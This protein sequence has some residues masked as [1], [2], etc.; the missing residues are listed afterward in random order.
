[1]VLFILFVSIEYFGYL[2]STIRQL[3][4]FTFLLFNGYVFVRYVL[5]PFFGMIRIGKRISP[6]QAARLLSKYYPDDLNDQVTNVLQL[7]KYLDRNPGNAGLIMAAIDQKAKSAIVF[8]FH[9]AISLKGN[10]RFL[11]Y[12]LL[13]LLVVLG[14]YLV[15]PAFLYEPAKR[16]VRYDM[17]FERPTPFQVEVVSSTEGFRHQDLEVVVQTHGEVVPSE[18]FLRMEGVRHPMSNPSSSTYS[19]TLRNLQEDK[20]FYVEAEGFTFGPFSIDVFEKPAFT[21]FHIEVDY[22][23]YS[24]LEKE[25]FS[26]MGDL[27]VLY[28]SQ[29]QWT[30]FTS[31]TDQVEFFIE[32]ETLDVEKVRKGEFSAS[33][34]ATESFDY[35]V[36]SGSEDRGRGDSLSYRV[37]VEKDAYPRIAVEEH[38]DEV[39]IAHLFYRGTIRDDF[40]FT[41]LR[42]FYRVMDQSQVSQE[43]EVPFKDEA[44]E[45]DPYMR[46]QTFYYHFDMQSVDVNPGET[47]EIY[48]EV[49]DN[50]PYHGPKSARSRV[51]SHYIPTE[52]EMVAEQRESEKR[53]QDGL[54]EGRGEAGDARD[55]VEELRRQLLESEGVGWE[56]RE[57][58]QELLDKQKQMEEHIKEMAEEKKEQEARSE[59][60]LEADE[61]LKER[62]EELQQLFDEV[63]SDEMKALFE[64]LQQ[65]MDDLDRD[66]IY[67]MLDQV[68]FEFRD[69]EHS[70]D[71]ALEMFRQFAME[72]LLQESIDRIENLHEKQD[73]LQEQT[74]QGED[75]DNLGNQQE[76]LNQ[77]YENIRDILDD[78]RETNESLS[79]PHTLDETQPT[80]EEISKSLQKAVEN[81]LENDLS[82]EAG[83]NQQDAM[84]QMDQ[85]SETLRGM[86]ERLFHEQL[87]EDARA[88]RML[89]E[90]L[91]KSSFAQEDLIYETQQANVNDPRFVEMIRDQRKI[92]SD[93]EI[94]E[95]SLIALG[96][97]QMAIRSYVNREVAEVQ[98]Q[99]RET[100]D[101]MINRR[102][103][104]AASRQQ[105]VMTHINNLTLML[106]E[107]LQDVQQ[108][109]AMGEGNGEDS[110]PGAGEPSF[111]NMREMQEQMNEMLEQIREGHQPMP[112]ET[113][114]EMSLS[115]QMARMAAEQEA[116]RN[117]LR[118]KEQEMR[119]QGQEMDEGLQDLQQQMEESEL[120]MLRKEL[121]SETMERQEDILTRLL[122][123]EQAERQQEQED[124]REGTTAIDYEISN[125]EEIFQYN[126]DRE[127]EVEMLRSLPP[128]LR[129]FFRQKVEMYF[130]HVD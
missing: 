34:P 116:I 41:G 103:H 30:F 7:K 123:H 91:L 98:Q 100:I 28:G 113:G 48:F 3:L 129:P 6:D 99:M 62:Q 54:R 27:E 25:E 16:L 72:R 40:G 35:S 119:N 97:R 1:M 85:L 88:I 65:K 45:I 128:R 64:E 124:I 38:R 52:E 26:N 102:Q 39:M 46:N 33:A 8:P 77:A 63:M 66:D 37:Q 56:Q 126:R 71:R 90:N 95:D 107:S 19:Y 57:M 108:Q 130:L 94:V 86:Q 44:V 55:Q 13:P 93:M 9:K 83:Q 49:F 87:A 10:Y 109:M 120:D 68:D 121:S 11:P 81:L 111:Q 104:Q 50:D 5:I 84:D 31:G 78:F 101:H 32:D 18:A 4:F 58:L 15:Q 117:E 42:M 21:H 2:D 106:N 36:F 105:Y 70:M 75:M 89:L 29:V 82:G 20:S 69:M 43:E 122:E 96:K 115:E 53:V 76:E 17:H 125:P 74:L 67:E 51:F 92:Q 24:G 12:V 23:A 112:G 80:E 118:R 47:V 73:G 14:V 110:D 59:Q 22:P 114:E 61:R 127:R 79:R 60:F